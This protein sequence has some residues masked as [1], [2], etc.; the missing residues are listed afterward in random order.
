M[1]APSAPGPAGRRVR[2]RL[3]RLASD[4]FFFV[5]GFTVRR[6]VSLVTLPVLTRVLTVHQFGML[7]VIATVRE[8]LAVIFQLG[9]PNAS[10]R[11]YY[12]CPDER[13]QR[14]MFGT[15]LLLL[16]T[17]SG[18]G[19]LLLA[20]AGEAVWRRVVGDVPFHPY[21]TLTIAS[22]FT[23]T[24][25]VLPRSLFRVTNRVPRWAALTAAHG[26]LT[27]ALSIALVVVG[28]LGALGVVVGHLA[29]S[30][31]FFVINFRY[32]RPHLAW[33]FSP[34]L[35]LRALAFGLPDV[36]V[37]VSTWA[38]RLADRLILQ[39]W[40]PLSVVGL[41][42]IGSMLGS[43]L[44]ELVAS[45]ANAAIL[46]FFYA[47]ARE[48]EPRAARKM[49]ADVAAYNAAVLAFLAL[50]AML[51][52]REAIL[53]LAPPQYLAAEAVVPLIAWGS[54]FQALAHVPARGIYLVKKTAVLPLVFG[55]PAL[56]NVGLNFLLIPSF[57][58]LGAAWATFLSY[59]ALFALILA[60]AQRVYPIPYDYG[61]MAK[62]LVVL[63]ALSWAKAL[64]P[65]DSLAVAVS[66]KA[67][68]LAAFPV[69][70]LALGFL[71]AGE[72][73]AVAGGTRRLLAARLLP[74]GAR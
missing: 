67:L 63:L 46:P 12:D 33:T 19:C 10:D 22:I 72:W 62:P 7:A 34:G 58:M 3:L 52:A 23:G 59:P 74:G 42:S 41:Y 50:G 40:V 55:V 56:L 66:L 8:L 30:A 54:V 1:S 48:T 14:R 64:I 45:S 39:A 28:D 44:F 38:V 24:M 37:R 60:V 53:V 71:D 49:F 18:V 27:A 11:F 4:T 43:T 25:G 29:G 5:A 35:A 68:L 6:A 69:A 9:V 15:L 32:L 36:P 61:R 13:A 47:T 73:R 31:V 20:W 2:G 17:T 70:L 21:I 26:V 51:F 65:T 57:G 16:M